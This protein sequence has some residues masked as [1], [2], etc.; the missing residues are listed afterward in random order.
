MNTD[1]PFSF[2]VSE[3]ERLNQLSLDFSKPAEAFSAQ[4]AAS[5]FSP[6]IVYVDESGD[7]HLEGNDK[8]YPV[9]V[10]AFCIFHKKYYADVLVPEMQSL[11]F[12][13]FGHDAIIFH[14]REIR[15]KLPPF[16]FQSRDIENAFMGS[17]SGII[18]SSKFVLIAGAIM[19][20]RLAA[21]PAR[22]AYHIA[23]TSCL[24]NLYRFLIEKNHYKSKTFIVVEARGDKEDRELELEF[25][26][27]CAGDNQL[28]T[29]FPFEIIIKSKQI[30]STGMQFADL[31]ARPIGRHLI[32]GEAKPNR[33]FDILKEK[34]FCQNPQR[35]GEHYWDYGLTVFPPVIQAKGP[36][37][38]SEP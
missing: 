28:K 34:F 20:Q 14:E 31:F 38:T 5:T 12:N 30:N 3:S 16:T 32:D 4:T 7:T 22:N 17:L 18:E 9:F 15:K 25:R 23:L 6:Y 13:Y 1:N 26:R 37:M 2:D 21:K 11:K 36:D 10:L 29:K 24:E 33:A 35:L 27:I 8:S 19:K